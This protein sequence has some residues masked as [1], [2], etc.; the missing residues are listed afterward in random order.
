MQGVGNLGGE[1]RERL[2]VGD[3]DVLE[4][5][6]DAVEPVVTAQRGDVP[7]RA[8]ARIGRHQHPVKD[9]LVEAGV[10]DQRDDLHLRLARLRDHARVHAAGD[11]AEAVHGERLRRDDGDPVGV[12]EE[13][14][15]ARLGVGGIPERLGR[16]GRGGGAGA[17]Q[18]GGEKYCGAE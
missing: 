15:H 9:P 1:R 5:E 3:V 11:D 17:G 12:R 18:Q 13:A 16:L 2:P 6:L 7:D 14:L 10:H 4:V 8:P